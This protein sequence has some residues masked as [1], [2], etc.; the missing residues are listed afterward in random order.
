MIFVI[1]GFQC[2]ALAQNKQAIENAIENVTTLRRSDAFRPF[3][4][5]D[6]ARCR[7]Y[8]RRKAVSYFRAEDA[9]VE[10][11]QHRHGGT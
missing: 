7:R 6:Q 8:K 3:G 1:D 2:R 11:E 10:R 9:I 5:D 4:A